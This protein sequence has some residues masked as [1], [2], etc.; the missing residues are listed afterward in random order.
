MPIFV[1]RVCKRGV[2]I[3]WRPNAGVT[4]QRCPAVPVNVCLTVTRVCKITWRG[5][6]MVKPLMPSIS[7]P[8]PNAAS[9]T[10]VKKCWRAWKNKQNICV[11]MWNVPRVGSIK[12]HT[13]VSF[14]WWKK[15]R[16]RKWRNERKHE[17]KYKKVKRGAA[18]GLA[19][20][21]TNSEGMGE[22]DEKPTPPLHVLF[23][24]E[25]MQDTGRR[26]PNFYPLPQDKL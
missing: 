16:K 14:K 15:T 11:V 17:K 4:E 20:L 25:A 1:L 3:T 18:A 5:P 7:A 9:V 23:D 22:E 10:A 26:I 2:R 21:R 12:K 24:I 19:I 8:V 13:N 6:T